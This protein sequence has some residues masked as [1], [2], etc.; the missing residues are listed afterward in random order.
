[1]RALILTI[2]MIFALATSGC[3]QNDSLQR[4]YGKDASY[5]EALS[6]IKEGN[7][8]EALNF[9]N[10]AEKSASTLV[11]HYAL[12]QLCVTGTAENR[13]AS[14]IRLASSFP[15]NEESLLIAT[16]ELFSQKEFQK[17][18]EITKDIDITR[19][20]NELAYY[21]LCSLRKKNSAG[22]SKPFFQ[23]CT[24]RPFSKWHDL[25]FIEC[26]QG[27]DS[28]KW[29][30]L[31]F[32][33]LVYLKKYTE[34][35]EL[36]KKILLHKKNHVPQVLSDTGKVFLYGKGDWQQN[37]A[38]L[39][40]LK[41]SLGDDCIFYADFYTARIL[42]RNNMISQAA[43][44]YLE[45][46]LAAEKFSPE[47][48]DNG[49]WYYFSSMLNLSPTKAIDA[50]RK[51][52][53]LIHD[54]SYYSDFYDTLSLRLVSSGRW[55]EYVDTAEFIAESGCASRDSRAKFCYTA[56]RLIQ[57]KFVT[58]STRPA[59]Y[60]LE[61][62]ADCQDYYYRTL[63]LSYIDSAADRTLICPPAEKTEIPAEVTEATVKT[64]EAK[65]AEKFL[66]GL[67]DYG[68]TEKLVEEY[69]SLCKKISPEL[70][71]KIFDYL[72]RCGQS[73]NHGT[74]NEQF[75]LSSIRLASRAF[76]STES[77]Y[78]PEQMKKLASLAFPRNY[79]E[80]VSRY[81]LEYQLAE[82]L[83]YA[84]IR[85]ESF[86]NRKVISH[87]GA[88]GLTQLMDS[89]AEDIANRLKIADY[90]ILDADTNIRFGCYYLHNLLQR[91]ENSVLTSA[92]AYNAGLSRVRSWKKNCSSIF[93]RSSVPGDLFLE[94]VPYAETR[95]YGRKILGAAAVYSWLYTEDS[96][97]DLCREYL[98]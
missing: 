24:E 37:I 21:R 23:W 51:H 38:T 82:S 3:A 56:A 85:S 46:A 14:S 36:T 20:N 35:Q 55:K 83:V 94:A 30:L 96:P 97:T 81:A 90:D 9:L 26:Y 89:T 68:H 92:L 93:G 74:T 45:A 16:R 88:M 32:R 52:H 60:F 39:Q 50:L 57:E 79:R 44:T 4:K 59:Q 62:A 34:A 65:A 8:E 77:T 43:E 28:Y 76:F 31:Y 48:T 7:E 18:A 86:F 42:E 1:M 13:L 11:R 66:E 2:S 15:E 84:V 75:A 17:V 40:E 12:R 64:E 95:E 71:L 10:R 6:S 78:S 91:T 33:D 61:L 54:R 53:A 87:A 98:K 41:P 70:S 67:M 80:E 73:H 47:H 29:D 27:Q 58:D 69:P 49:L 19:C 72:Y 22:F 63:A 5:F 25:L